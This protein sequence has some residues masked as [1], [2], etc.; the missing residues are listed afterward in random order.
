MEQISNKRGEKGSDMNTCGSCGFPLK[1]VRIRG[2]TTVDQRCSNR[3]CSGSVSIQWAP[4]PT[5]PGVQRLADFIDE[6]QEIVR[7]AARTKNRN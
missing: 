5:P 1:T 2:L 7:A 4:S 3:S 6:F